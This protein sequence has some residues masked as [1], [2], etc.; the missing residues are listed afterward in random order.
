MLVTAM[1]EKVDSS[2]ETLPRRSKT[3]AQPF[4]TEML[5]NVVVEMERVVKDAEASTTQ[6]KLQ[7]KLAKEEEEMAMERGEV[8]LALMTGISSALIEE[9]EMDVRE[10]DDAPEMTTIGVVPVKDNEDSHK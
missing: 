6:P 7:P 4:A 3:A 5:E 1:S 2:I 10:R 9:I 8:P